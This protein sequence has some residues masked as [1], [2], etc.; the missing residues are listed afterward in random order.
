MPQEPLNLIEVY[1]GLIYP[2][3]ERM[4]KIMETKILDL[5]DVG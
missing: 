3:R 1:S 5:R 4:A 2:R